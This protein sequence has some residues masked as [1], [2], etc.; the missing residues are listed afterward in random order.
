MVWMVDLGGRPSVPGEKRLNTFGVSQ[1]FLSSVR[2]YAWDGT[3]GMYGTHGMV[4]MAT[5]QRSSDMAS[6]TR[7]SSPSSSLSTL[8]MKKRVSSSP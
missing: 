4:H 8:G 7:W 5:H 6:G 1:E 2:V 3:H